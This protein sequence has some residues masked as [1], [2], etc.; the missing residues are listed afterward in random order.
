MLTRTNPRK[1]KKNLAREWTQIF[2]NIG[3]H[4]E[5]SCH[6]SSTAR[7]DQGTLRLIPKTLALRA[8]Q[9]QTAA[10]RLARP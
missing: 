7:L 2:K 6:N 8:V 3:N 10:S 1:K 5:L 9:R 4:E